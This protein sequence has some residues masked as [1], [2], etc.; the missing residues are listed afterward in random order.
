MKGITDNMVT[1]LEKLVYIVTY[2]I[3]GQRW[4]QNFK[5]SAVHKFE[6]QAR[7]L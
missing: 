1:D 2:V 4:I 5:I 7:G 3:I 6:N